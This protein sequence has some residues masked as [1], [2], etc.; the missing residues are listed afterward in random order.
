MSNG[1]V[2]GE[3][4]SSFVYD[5]RMD[6]LL[7]ALEKIV[8]VQREVLEEIK[9]LRSDMKDIA[10]TWRENDRDQRY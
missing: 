2:Y 7:S 8:D 3:N 10:I 9:T 6:Q 5:N 4:N 1:F